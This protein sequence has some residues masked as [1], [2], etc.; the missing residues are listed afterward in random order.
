MIPESIA[1]LLTVPPKFK[2]NRSLKSIENSKKQ[3]MVN[4]AISLAGTP[5]QGQYLEY[6][7]WVSPNYKVGVGKF[8]KEYYLNH[9]KRKDGS[10]GNN[11][12]DMRPFV[13]ILRNN[14]WEDVVF[15]GSFDHVFQFFQFVDKK[16]TAALEILG[17][18]MFRNAHLLDH[19]K[20]DSGN[21][22]YQPPQLAI[23]YLNHTI[24]DFDGISIEAYLHYLEMI[25]WNEDTKYHGLGF[26]ITT[27]I[28]RTNNMLTY[29]HI[30]AVLLGR[31]SLSKLCS[32]FSRPP[33][34]V[35]AIALAT[36]S[37]AFTELNII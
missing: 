17:C 13:K 32:G 8:G 10:V 24:G 30:I 33:V 27:G 18:L 14:V 34:G 28:G 23:D 7:K 4:N 11:P 21:W 31:A 22:T 19:H 2:G 12:N 5:N 3:E 20:D 6:E 36:A 37:T 16:D 35:S 29:C 25:A 9:I 15:D 1:K 26:D